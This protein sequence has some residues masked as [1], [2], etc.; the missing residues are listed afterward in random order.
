M[1]FAELADVLPH[2]LPRNREV[3]ERV[4][5][6]GVQEA[7][8]GLRS[9]RSPGDMLPRFY[10]VPDVDGLASRYP[11]LAH[12][13]HTLGGRHSHYEHASARWLRNHCPGPA[14][15]PKHER[16]RGKELCGS[17]DQ[18]AY[19]QQWSPF[20][21]SHVQQHALVTIPITAQETHRADDRPPAQRAV[22]RPLPRARV[23]LAGR[24][25][26]VPAAGARRDRGE[27]GVRSTTLR[28]GRSEV[29]YEVVA[30]YFLYRLCRSNAAK[31]APMST[32]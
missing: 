25:A 20:H 16:Q 21:P 11:V 9:L 24:A 8:L 5:F 19:L 17:G 18:L 31:M 1:A 2:R 4:H 3:G 13:E 23:H 30:R 22:H 7:L 29:H 26:G 14:S 32:S 10:T 27:E 15:W 28:R 6:E 12:S